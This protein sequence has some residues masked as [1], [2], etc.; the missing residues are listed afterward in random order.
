MSSTTIEITTKNSMS[1]KPV[2]RRCAECGKLPFAQPLPPVDRGELLSGSI[3]VCF[4]ELPCD[5]TM[6][7]VGV[8]QRILI[9]NWERWSGDEW[10]SS[11]G[12]SKIPAHLDEESKRFGFSRYMR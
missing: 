1:V 10:S 11:D 9:R 6:Q 8:F 12:E 7:S 4:S 3:G 5:V 2:G